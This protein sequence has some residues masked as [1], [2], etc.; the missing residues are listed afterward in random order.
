VN[1]E[2]QAAVK[3]LEAFSYSISHDLRAPL[4][5]VNGFSEILL[6]KHAP[7][8][9]PEA[10]GYLRLVRE[11]GLYMSQLIDGLLEFS[12][13]SRQPLQIALAGIRK[14]AQ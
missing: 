13:L 1:E 5:A 8:L 4:R 7:Q 14:P 10:Q 9:S 3:E 2:L 12:R 11:N 6:K